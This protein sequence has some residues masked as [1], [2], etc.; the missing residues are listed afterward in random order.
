[1]NDTLEN[2]GDSLIQH[3]KSNDRAYLMKV[4]PQDCPAVVNHAFKLAVANGYSKIFAKAGPLS[5]E[6]FLR[7]GFHQEAKVP[8]LFNGAEDGYFLSHY[9]HQQRSREK[10]PET[11]RKV[12]ATAH[13]KFA[14]AAPHAGLNAEFSWRVMHKRDVQAMAALYR[15]VFASYPFPIDDSG[16]LAST[17]DEDVIYHGICKDDEL[18]AL[19]SAEIDFAG[20]NVEMTDFAT[21]PDCR[22]AG[23]ATCLLDKMEEDVR[24]RGIRTAYTIARAYSY[25]M[26]ITFAKHGY[27]F[28]GTLANNTQIF[29][30]LESMNVWYKAL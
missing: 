20:K 17:M 7:R 21:R 5:S 6:A 27:R 4:S 15:Q 3:G 25:G 19:S 10:R 28:A 18:V 11:V 9:M 29:G 23:L 14:E 26:N 2:F 30:Q 22:G 24:R 8:R 1:M 12:L 13:D 16:Y